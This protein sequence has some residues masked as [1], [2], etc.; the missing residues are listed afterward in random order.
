MPKNNNKKKKQMTEEQNMKAMRN[1]KILSSVVCVLIG[2]LVAMVIKGEIKLP[3]LNK[4][5]E[6]TEPTE[7]TQAV[8]EV[9]PTT[10]ST[11][12]IAVIEVENYGTITMELDANAA[13]QTVA[14]FV[15]LVQ[16][17]FYDGLTFHRIIDGFM[18]QGG[19][20]KGNGTGGSGTTIYGEFASNGF[21]NPLSH[22]RG[23]V[24]MARSEKPD[25]A[26]S[27][28]F[29]V[30]KDSTYLDGSYAVFG[31][32]T[33][34]MDVV[35]QICADARPTDGNGTIPASEQPVITSIT[36]TEAG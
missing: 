36:V 34:G 11:T 3:F 31:Y 30:H 4:A 33:E 27:Q 2:M 26:S 1:G 5:E 10:A 35:D 23:A 9:T 7:T 16:E 8:E 21:D 22:T 12:H 20:P 17:G 32:V 15:K 13:P 14:N 28:F 29:I 25:S 19:D 18:I 24:S 6:T